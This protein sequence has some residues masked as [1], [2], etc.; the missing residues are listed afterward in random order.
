[1]RRPSSSG[2]SSSLAAEVRL[3][4]DVSDARH[5]GVGSVRAVL[6]GASVGVRADLVRADRGA[7]APCVVRDHPSAGARPAR[8]C[9]RCLATP[10]C[11]DADHGGCV[12]VGAIVEG[13][14]RRVRHDQ[15]TRRGLPGVPRRPGRPASRGAEQPVR[16]GTGTSSTWRVVRERF[17]VGISNPKSVVFFAAVLPHV[18]DR[19]TGHVP[20]QLLLLGAIFLFAALTSDNVG[21]AAA[22]SARSWFERSPRRL[23]HLGGIGGV[24]MIGIRAR[25]AVSGR[26]STPTAR[27]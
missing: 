21:A 5:P 8:S 25:A 4:D 13:V 6:L 16:H 2:P 20:V 27:R 14:D 11:L 19:S 9:P 12:W 23:S 15:I 7:R 18:I 3:R 24:V 22:G 26:P 17:I 10:S 1:M